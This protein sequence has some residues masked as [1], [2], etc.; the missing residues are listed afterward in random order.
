MSP[1][2][3]RKRWQELAELAA[4]ERD[5]DK[6]RALIRELTEALDQQSK[7]VPPQTPQN[8]SRR[9]LFVDDEEGIRTTLPVL[10]EQR[11]FPVRVAASV[12]E[13]ANPAL[14]NCWRLRTHWQ[15]Y[16]C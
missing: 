13:A 7:G 16:D 4:H 11:G 2:R 14:M 8:L 15:A 6:L 5:A 12:A 1:D 10:L 9:L 3:P